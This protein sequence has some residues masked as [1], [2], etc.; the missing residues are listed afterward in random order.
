MVTVFLEL[1]CSFMGFVLLTLLG[2][3]A[4]PILERTFD[5]K[6]FYKTNVKTLIFTAIGGIIILI[7]TTFLPTYNFFIETLVG[8]KVVVDNIPTLFVTAGVLGTILKSFLK[9]SV[10]KAKAEILKSN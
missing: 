4:K 1:L 8:G 3:A 10:T 5:I 7:F 9:K 2:Q 6:V